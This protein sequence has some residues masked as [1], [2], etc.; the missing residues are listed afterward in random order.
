MNKLLASCFAATLTAALVHAGPA[1]DAAAAAKKIAD[2]ANYSWTA[3]TEIAN[4]QFP[5]MPV[6]GVTEKGGYTVVTREF[7][8]N[9]MQTVRKGEQVVSQNMEGAWMTAEEMR[10]QFANRAGGG[11]GGGGGG[12]RGGG[13]GFGGGFGM[14]GG[15]N[16]PADDAAN[17]AAKIKDAKLVDGAIVGT[18][19]TDDA[20]ALMTFG[21]GRGGRGGGGGG[22]AP[23]PKNASASVKFWVKDGVLAKYILNVKG[24]V[25]FGGEDRDMDRTTTTEF[26]NVG[27]T[28]VTVPEEAKKK[29]GT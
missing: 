5:A 26:K 14:G 17:L 18:L 25:S 1:D 7:N 11:G 8:G 10:Q 16:N 24:T 21:G 29:L 9:A 19:S 6:N 12:N 3:T 4:S 2:A 22:Q 13:R 23:A 28:K 15:Q 20:A 27:S